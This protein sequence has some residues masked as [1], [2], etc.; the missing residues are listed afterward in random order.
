M[1]DS[2]SKINNNAPPNCAPRTGHDKLEC[3]WIWN[4]SDGAQLWSKLLKW[5]FTVCSA[6]AARKVSR[7]FGLLDSVVK[8]VNEL[9]SHA[10]AIQINL[11]ASKLGG[12][13]Y[14]YGAIRYD[15]HLHNKAPWFPQ[16]SEKKHP[17]R[18]FAWILFGPFSLMRDL[19]A[20]IWLRGCF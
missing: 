9:P 14:N 16:F 3:F 8:D 19:Y 6:K 17:T 13:C 1:C 10:I 18:N 15:F 7:N 2:R 20:W 4:F 5:K 12:R 11:V